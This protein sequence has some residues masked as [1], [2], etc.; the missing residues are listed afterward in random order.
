MISSEPR[1]TDSAALTFEIGSLLPLKTA[2]TLQI[3]VVVLCD[4]V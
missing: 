1:S 4:A 3:R 2:E